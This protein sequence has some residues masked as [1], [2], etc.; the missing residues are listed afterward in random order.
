MKR[1]RFAPRLVI[2]LLAG[3]IFLGGASIAAAETTVP[4]KTYLV[5]GTGTIR[6][7]SLNAAKEQAIAACKSS[8]VQLMTAELMPLEILVQQFPMVDRTIFQKADQFIQYY[9]VLSE[10]REERR[11]RVL[12][13]AKVSA[14]QIAD[15]LRQAGILTADTKPL[16]PLTVTVV[17][18]QDLSSFVLFRSTLN[19]L[20]G[21]ESV[22]NREIRPNQTTLAVNYRGS[23]GTFAE[24]LVVKKYAGFTAR[25]YEEAENTFRVELIPDETP[26]ATN[27][28]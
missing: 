28:N 19:Q 8:A 4:A 22:Q 13:Q 9:K 12:V 14:R 25:V 27:T 23:T 18:T 11:Y 16:T 26:G 20:E 1:L 2:R 3:F 15:Q 6:G 5:V 10:N 21:V 24:A 17:G 7:D